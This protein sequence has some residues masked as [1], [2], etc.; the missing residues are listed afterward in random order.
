MKIDRKSLGY[1]VLAVGVAIVGC[2]VAVPS[3][4]IPKIL[5]DDPFAISGVAVDS[6]SRSSCLE[7]AADS[8]IVYHLF[9]T[10]ALDNETFDSLIVPGTRSR[11]V[12]AARSDLQVSCGV[13]DAVD[14]LEVIRFED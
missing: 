13:G 11:L 3:I 6:G 1:L 5:P 4:E 7:W 12:L 8:G 10:T 2:T 9:Q 14:V